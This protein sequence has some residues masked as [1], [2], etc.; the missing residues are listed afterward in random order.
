[1]PDLTVDG[2]K[3]NYRCTGDGEPVVLSFCLGGNLSMWGPEIDSLAKHYRVIVWDPRGHGDS[4]SPTDPAQYGVRRSA[5]DL[6]AVLDHLG[7]AQAIVGGVSM[8]A[9]IAA[10]FA[11]E[12]PERTKAVLI[13]DSNTAAGLPVSAEVAAIRTNTIA[14]CE[15]GDMDAVAEYFLANSPAYRLFAA[16]SPQNEARLHDMI[17][18]INPTGFANTLRSMLVAETTTEDLLRITAPTLVLAGEKDPAMK[19]IELTANTISHCTFT[20]VDNAGH[21]SNIDQPELFAQ[22]VSEFLNSVV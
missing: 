14:L 21:L 16:K 3:L 7:Y 4:A 12:F 19:A 9:G 20:K 10:C 1:M 17:K 8:G 22:A 5:H 2:I 6:A 11:G 13:I 15:S 18:S